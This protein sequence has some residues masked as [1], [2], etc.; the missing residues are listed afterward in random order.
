MLFSALGTPLGRRNLLIE[1][2]G[3]RQCLQPGFYQTHARMLY[4]SSEPIFMPVADLLV[5]DHYSLICFQSVD[6]LVGHVLF[7]VRELLVLSLDKL[8]SLVPVVRSFS[9]P[10]HLSLQPLEPIAFSD[11]YVELLTFGCRDIGLYPEVKTYLLSVLFLFL[12]VLFVNEAR[13][14]QV[15]SVGFLDQ[16]RVG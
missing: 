8:D 13:H 10:R 2:Y 1:D 5:L 12:E 3:L 7:P 4:L 15:V 14:L 6:Q 16:V 9:P 11:R